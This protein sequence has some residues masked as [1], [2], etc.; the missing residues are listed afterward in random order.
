MTNRKAYPSDLN[1]KEWAILEPLL[2]K[3]GMGRPRQH[4]ERELLNAIWYILRTGWSWRMLPHDFPAWQSVYSYFRMLKQR[5]I[6]IRL[7]DALREQGRLQAGREAEPSTLVGD[8]QSV[9]TTE[10]GALVAMMVA[11]GSRGASA[12]LS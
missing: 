12:T 3:T 10:K 2:P 7:N 11:S 4:A 1:D 6:W 5:G 8:S 9:K